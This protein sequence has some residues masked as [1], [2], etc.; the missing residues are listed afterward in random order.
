M[1]NRFVAENKP[2]V[3]M[4]RGAN[5][6]TWWNGGLRTTVYFH[7]MIGLLTETIGN[8][9]PMDIPFVANRQLPNG[10]LPFPIQP[11][12]W[13]FRSSVDYSV[14]ANYAVLDVASRYREQFLHNIYKMGRNSI[15]RGSRDH[16]TVMPK[17]VEAVRAAIQSQGRTDV[18]GV[19]APGGQTREALN[20]AESKRAMALLHA[21]ANRDPRG[22]ILPADQPDFPTAIKFIN[23]L[24][25]TGVEVHRATAAF[26]VG[27]K[28]YPAGSYVVKTAQ[29]FR[30]H[31]MDMFEPQDHPNDFRYPGGPPIPPYDNA[32]WTLAYQM[33]VRFDRILEGFDGPFERVNAWNVSPP[34]GRVIGGQASGYLFSPRVNDS[35][36]AMNRLLAGGETVYRLTRPT[37]AGGMRWEPGTFYVPARASTRPML[38]RMATEL[39]LTFA[40]TNQKP[41]GEHLQ[42]RPIRIGLW[43]RYGGSMPSGWTR[44]ILEQFETPYKVVFTQELDA[45]GLR[46]KFD[47]LVFVSD[48]I[49]E[50]E[51]DPGFNNALSEELVPAQL[52]NTLGRITVANTVPRLREFMEGGGTVITIGNSNALARHLGLPIGNKLVEM[53][54][55]RERQLPREKFYIPGSVLQLRVDNTHPLAWGMDERVDVMFDNSPVFAIPPGTRSANRVAWFDSKEPLRSGWAW[56]QEQLEGGVAVAEADVGRGKLF[57]FGPEVLFRAQPHGTFKFFFNGL[58]YGT[59]QRAAVR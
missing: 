7:N 15:E 18:D 6:S 59:A 5:Y 46:D 11:Q 43:D 16:W 26:R 9:T 49:P 39:G 35:F 2:G 32:G 22:Y 10:D 31:V 23:S 20:P 13:H 24:R 34:A 58:T 50:R 3:T 14:T 38:E 8:P 19:M 17:R 37:T 57:M 55:G 33:G 12:R 25:E 42:L 28:S 1:H 29:A 40:G 53:V 21:P 54:D 45:G 27:G 41:G 30:P 48:A 52:R 56:G 4:R 51:V 47:V 36:R 44:W